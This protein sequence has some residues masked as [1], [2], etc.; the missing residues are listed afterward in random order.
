M[1]RLLGV[2]APGPT[3]LMDLLKTEIGPFTNLS[4]VHCDGWGLGY[5][6]D[7]GDLVPFSIGNVTFAHNG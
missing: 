3:K 7:R 2:V 5:W 6:D 1:C 4:A